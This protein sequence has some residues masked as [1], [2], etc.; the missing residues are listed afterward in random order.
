MAGSFAYRAWGQMLIDADDEVRALGLE[1][2]EM[3]ESL[4]AV[5]QS[6]WRGARVEWRDELASI[7]DDVTLP[8]DVRAVAGHGVQAIDL[9]RS[10]EAATA[11]R[12]AIDLL[13]RIQSAGVDD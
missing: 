10:P 12:D 6:T 4:L 8:L 13:A 3:L 7:R 1:M 11:I 5:V 2:L 9:A